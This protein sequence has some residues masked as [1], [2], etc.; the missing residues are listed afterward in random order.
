MINKAPVILLISSL[1]CLAISILILKY[2]SKESKIYNQMKECDIVSS[3]DGLESMGNKPFL[4]YGY[5]KSDHKATPQNIVAYIETVGETKYLYSPE[6]EISLGD[7]SITLQ[8]GYGLADYNAY[9][10]TN[11]YILEGIKSGNDITIYAINHKDEKFSGIKGY[12][13]YP[14]NPRQYVNFLASP[15]NE[16]MVYVRIFIGVALLLFL[17]SIVLNIKK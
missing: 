5:I 11:R 8:N 2:G 15:Y 4:L 9:K 7:S 17:M 16:Y 13:L 1:I 3:L 14:G 6:L 10:E 12:E